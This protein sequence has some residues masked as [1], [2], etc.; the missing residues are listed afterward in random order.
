[1]TRPHPNDHE[2]HGPTG[3]EL[4]SAAALR[5]SRTM[6]NYSMVGLFVL[7]LLVVLYHIGDFMVPVIGAILLNL[8]LSPIARTLRR[9]HIP[10]PVSAVVIVVTLFALVAASFYGLSS[11]VSRWISAIPEAVAKI[12]AQMEDMRAP[13]QTVRRATSEVAKIASGEDDGDS[14]T[15]E[16]QRVVV[17][18][19]SL[20]IRIFGSVTNMVLQTGLMFV[21][22]Y[23]LLA[24]G[25]LFQS[26]LIRIMPRLRDKLKAQHM[27]AAVVHDISIY[28]AT[29]TLINAVL[30]TAV[31][32]ALFA[33]DFPNPLLW[34]V[35]AGLLN[36]VPYLGAVVGVSIVAVASFISIEPASAAILP[37]LS[38]AAIN[39]LEGQF[40]TPSIVSRNLTLNPVVVFLS[41]S[42]FSWFWGIPGALMAVPILVIVKILSGYIVALQP[43]GE[44]LSGWPAKP[45][46]PADPEPATAD[47]DSTS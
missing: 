19:P 16:P 11:P 5:R 30:G 12:E 14:R 47:H 33:L 22:L 3:P 13:L 2:N 35:M 39:V 38:Y 37:P 36:Y 26:K 23:F 44:F 42:F 25:N 45:A 28:L 4:G 1:M 31:G 27:A 40:I 46:L 41:V 17:G 24:V 20:T 18:Q 21:L 6:A 10:Y 43:I 32:L 8:I 15:Q 34:G 9:F 7:A 29:I